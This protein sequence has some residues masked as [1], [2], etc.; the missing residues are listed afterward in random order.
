MYK[1][2]RNSLTDIENKLVATT[3]RRKAERQD[4]GME[5]TRYKLL[6]VK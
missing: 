5:L 1:Q 4:M 3:G 2:N 6:C